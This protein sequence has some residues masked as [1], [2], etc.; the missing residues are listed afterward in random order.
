MKSILFSV[1]ALGAIVGG[2]G[3]ASAQ[4]VV[5]NPEICAQFYPNANCQNLGEGS[6]YT[7]SYQRGL[8]NGGRDPVYNS[9][10]DQ[11]YNRYDGGRNNSYRRRSQMS[12]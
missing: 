1:I 8:A 6:P 7:G 12:R 10:F 3:S 5:S 2:I 9:G 4:A 11:S